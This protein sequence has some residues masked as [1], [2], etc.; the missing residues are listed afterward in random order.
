MTVSRK[1]SE[2]VPLT[3]DRILDSAMGLADEDGIESLTMRRLAEQ[4]EVEA[5]SL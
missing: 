2:R 3:R 5:M 4:L 1:R